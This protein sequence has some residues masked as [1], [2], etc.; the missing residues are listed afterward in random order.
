MS[1]ARIY[2][3]GRVSAILTD[4]PGSLYFLTLTFTLTGHGRPASFTG[5]SYHPPGML[6]KNTVINE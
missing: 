3:L 2:L 5:E 4:L 6:V 1:L